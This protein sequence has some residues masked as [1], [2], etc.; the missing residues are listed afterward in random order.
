MR[1]DPHDW[2]DREF[3]L[4]TYE[5]HLVRIIAGV[6]RPGDVC[7][8][9]G[10][11]KGFITLHLACAVGPAGRVI[12]F[13]PDPRAVNILT[14]NCAYNGLSNTTILPYG[15]ADVSG[16]CDFALCRQLG[17]SSMFPNPIAAANII[18]TISAQTKAL[19]DLLDELALTP[20]ARVSFLKIDAEG[21]EPLILAGAQRTLER[22]RPIV[23][24]EVNKSSLNASQKSPEDIGRPLRSLGYRLYCIGSTRRGLS[25]KLA[26]RPVQLLDRDLDDFQNVLALQPV[27]HDA[28]HLARLL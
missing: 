4:G 14:A 13:E 27:H 28:D 3:Y 24:I 21:S 2:M 7:I 10:A 12:S 8:D 9:V 26:L 11:Q 25:T 18:G 1:I 23:H 6:V 15:L 16:H 20:A 17:W 22:F 19:D 5:R